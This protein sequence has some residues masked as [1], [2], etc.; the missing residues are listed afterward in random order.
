M[1]SSNI[2]GVMVPSWARRSSSWIC[3]AASRFGVDAMICVQPVSVVPD[4]VILL[5][6]SP[7]VMSVAQICCENP[8]SMRPSPA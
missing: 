1:P 7:A 3:N 6:G 4:S 5:V 2:A 8:D